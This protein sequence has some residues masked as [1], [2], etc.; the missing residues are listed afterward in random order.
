MRFF[1]LIALL[2]LLFISGC[3]SSKEALSPS[4]SFM[5]ESQT[6]IGIQGNIGLLGP[7]FIAEKENKYMWHFWGTEDEINQQPFRVEAID[8]N[9]NKKIQTLLSDAGTK[10]E[11]LVWEYNGELGGP[12]NGANAHLPSNMV[13][14][15]SGLWQLNAYLGG[16]LKGSII[17]DVKHSTN[18]NYS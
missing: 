9:T 3:T 2:C 8:L 11:Q 7:D 16:K 5:S 6:M 17:V 13:L 15:S 1:S 10:N 18:E 14:P 4:S 12:N